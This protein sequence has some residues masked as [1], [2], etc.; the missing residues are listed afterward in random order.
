MENSIGKRVFR[1]T[2]VIVLVGIAAKFTSFILEAV[3][4]AYLGTTYQSDAFYMVSGVQAVFYPMFSIGIWKVFL[5]LYKRNYACGHPEEADALSDQVISFFSIASFLAVVLLIL[6]AEQVVST[7]APGFVGETRALCVKLVRL[8]APM[9]FFIISAAI[10]ATMLQAHNKFLG[11]QIREVASHIPTIVAALFFYKKFGIEAMALG[12]VA[13]GMVRLLIELPFVDWGYRFRPDFRFHA[14]EFRLLL[15][16]MPSALIS[17]GVGQLNK[18]IDRAMASTLPE[19][20]ISSLNYGSKLSSVF[21][22]LLSTSISTALYPQTIELIALKKTDALGKLITRIISIFCVVM[23][24][25]TLACVLFREELVA[26]AFQRGAFA[27]ES[28]ALTAGVFAMYCLGLFSGAS[29]AV[30]SNIFYGFG[31]TRTPMQ[32]SLINLVTNVLLNLVLIRFFMAN[33]LALATSLSSIITFFVRLV[34]VRRYVSLDHGGMMIT[35]LKVL[36]AAVAAC[37]APRILFWIYPADAWLVLLL[38]AVIGG[39]LFYGILRLLRVRALDDLLGIVQKSLRDLMN[40]FR[41]KRED[42]Q[43]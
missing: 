42:R 20:T 21:G 36:A 5:P 2:L 28:T 9:Y 32:I 13:G 30:I 27:A 3:L 19:G 6:F 15:K 24:P 11:S 38:A 33:G 25:V 12:L 7:V 41:S 26:A 1:G 10:Y 18:L 23:V 29:N 37:S 22:G 14:P 35:A 8:S 40:N 31:D 39:G 43:S 16:R 34:L 17:A 4:A